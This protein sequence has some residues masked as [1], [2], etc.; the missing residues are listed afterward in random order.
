MAKS[1][2]NSFTLKTTG[3]KAREL[4][5]DC[6]ISL[7]FTPAT[8]PGEKIKMVV[9][10]FK[11]KALWDTGATGCVI[12]SEVARKMGLK[13]IGK[14][15]VHH[16]KGSSEHNVY[17]VSLFMPNGI[18]IPSIKITECDDTSGMFGFIIGMDIITAGDFS[19]TNMNGVT[20]FSFRMPSMKEIDYFGG[21]DAIK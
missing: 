20:T 1:K 3:G 8:K 7:P 11:T 9:P 12:T 19:I 21:D 4:V 13:P 16:A 18:A 2:T 6:A 15:L 10:P 17:L 5:T 14:A